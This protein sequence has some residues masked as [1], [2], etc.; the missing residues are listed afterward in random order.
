MSLIKLNYFV[1]SRRYFV[2][3]N[4]LTS[5]TCVASIFSSRLHSFNRGGGFRHTNANFLHCLGLVS[6][7]CFTPFE[8]FEMEPKHGGYRLNRNNMCI[9]VFVIGG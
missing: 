8:F 1:L 5:I 6:R 7:L 9:F 3:A 2:I 4:Y